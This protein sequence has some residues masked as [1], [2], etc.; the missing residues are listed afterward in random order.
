MQSAG[1]LQGG[2]PTTDTQANYNMHI[3]L[4]GIAVKDVRVWRPGPKIVCLHM[5]NVCPSMIFGLQGECHLPCSAFLVLKYEV[6]VICWHGQQL[7]HHRL[8]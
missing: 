1:L 5:P 4:H 8:G 2:Q 3:A 7:V 6:Q